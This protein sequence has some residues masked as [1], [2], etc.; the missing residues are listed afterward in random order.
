MEGAA[1]RLQKEAKGYLDSLR[2]GLI[3]NQQLEAIRI[4][5]SP[6][7]PCLLGASKGGAAE[8]GH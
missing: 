8:N 6:P 1:T 7:K 2:G 3:S 4:S 5:D